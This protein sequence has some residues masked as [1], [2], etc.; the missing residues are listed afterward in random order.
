MTQAAVSYQ[1]KLLEERLGTALFAR[2]QKQVALTEA[3]R[4]AGPWCRAPSIRS[5][6]AFSAAR[7]T[8]M[9]SDG[10]SSQ[11]FASNWLARNLGGF[12]V[13]RPDLALR[14]TTSDHCD[15]FRARREWD[16]A[17]AGL[18]ARRP[19]GCR[20][21]FSDANPLHAMC[22]PIAAIGSVRGAGR[23]ARRHPAQPVRRLV[24]RW[25]A[26][27]VSSPQ[28]LSPPAVLRLDGQ[29]FDGNAAMRIR[30]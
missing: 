5:T 16:V 18:A 11:T 30:A 13:S 2:D 7:S 3:G 1:V 12:Q 24:E 19:P 20:F 15:R 27:P 6:T 8:T 28:P 22:S 23:P 29:V 10:S 14:R 26:G 25:F 9:R 21:A 4:K 17:V